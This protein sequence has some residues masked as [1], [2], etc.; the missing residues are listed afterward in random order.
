MRRAIFRLAFVFCLCIYT[1]LSGFSSL[2]YAQE[3]KGYAIASDSEIETLRQ[4]NDRIINNAKGSSQY[5]SYVVNF[6]DKI[7]FTLANL[8]SL[9]DK[10]IVVGITDGTLREEEIK[11]LKNSSKI[12][13]VGDK[14]SIKDEVLLKNNLKFERLSSNKHVN[15]FLGNKDLLMVNLENNVDVLGALYYSYYYN[16]NLM[17]VDNSFELTQDNIELLKTLDEYNGLYFYDGI[18]PMDDSIKNEAY[19]AIKRDRSLI[20][21][22]NLDGKDVFKIFKDRLYSSTNREN[23]YVSEGNSLV[24]MLSTYV[25]AEKEGSVFFLVN[26]NRDLFRVE[27]VLE[28]EKFNNTILITSKKDDTFIRFRQILGYISGVDFAEIDI[29]NLSGKVISKSLIVD[30]DIKEDSKASEEVKLNKNEVLENGRVINKDNRVSSASPIRTGTADVSNLKYKRVIT[31]T[32]TA[33]SADPRENGGYTVTKLGTPLRAGVV[34]VDPNVIPLGTKL[35]IET[36]DGYAS[37]GY[38]VAEDT[39]SAIKGKKIDLFIAD[40]A[41]VR[42]FGRRQVKVY[43]LDEN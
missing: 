38:A 19:K 10:G 2:S 35:Y 29:K 21:N 13:V 12:V 34:A 41:Q 17:F 8:L 26:N 31:M 36:A 16:M 3:I 9:N 1:M 40:K 25:L 15:E 42:A 5:N 24:D 30:S 7:N 43:I 6:E 37:Y 32:A 4:V 20:P 33:Y 22:Y 28:T 14:N 39:G 18:N 27:K 23:V 11:V